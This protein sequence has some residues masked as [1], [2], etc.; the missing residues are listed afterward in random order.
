MRFLVPSLLATV[1]LLGASPAL[2]ATV[3]LTGATVID[4]T[5]AKRVRADIGIRQGHIAEIGDLAGATGP[6]IDA[7]GLV[8]APGFINI[9]DHADA[10]ALPVPP[11]LPPP[12]PPQA[13]KA[14][15]HTACSST[16]PDRTSLAG[17]IVGSS[18]RSLSRTACLFVC[19][20]SRA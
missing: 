1:S 20:F 18:L 3:A 2:A 8:V 9:H 16:R 13:T 6:A 17:I 5:G 11:E 12:P 14:N 19:L 15:A 4:G 10:K 7:K